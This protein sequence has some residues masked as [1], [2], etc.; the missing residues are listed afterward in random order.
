MAVLR[1]FGWLALLAR[2][3]RAKDA[4][5]L[6]PRHQVAVLQRQAGPTEAVLGRPRDLVRAGPAAAR[7]RSTSS[8]ASL[9]AAERADRSA[10]RTWLLSP[11]P[12][13]EN[14]VRGQGTV[15]EHPCQRAAPEPPGEVRGRHGQDRA[16]SV[17]HAIAAHLP[18]NRPGQGAPAACPQDKQ[19]IG[20]AGG[21]DQDQAGLASLHERPDRWKPGGELAQHHAE[22]V[23]EAVIG[24]LS[25]DSAEVRAGCTPFGHIAAGRYPRQDGYQEGIIGAGQ[26]LRI[27][28]GLEASR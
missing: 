23:L 26:L 9:D 21:I 5:I 7:R 1:V 28:Q 27:T 16:V 3:D 6:L 4:E 12:V 19:V 15:P 14:L 18:G 13:V 11:A 10:T 2:S 20:M 24:V 22:R 8:S 17:G 25:P